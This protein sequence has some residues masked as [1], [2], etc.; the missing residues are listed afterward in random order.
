MRDI[1]LP[2]INKATSTFA[3]Y[4]FYVRVISKED[5]LFSD[6]LSQILGGKQLI[7]AVTKRQTIFQDLDNNVIYL[8]RENFKGITLSRVFHE[9]GHRVFYNLAPRERAKYLKATRMSKYLPS[10][11]IIASIPE[12]RFAEEYSLYHFQPD[13]VRLATGAVFDFMRTLGGGAER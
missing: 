7:G 11:T 9:I 6:L 8:I 2:T 4:G 12:E 13:A 3:K 10:A 1:A 5:P